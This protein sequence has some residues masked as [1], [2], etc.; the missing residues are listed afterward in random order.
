MIIAYNPGR[1]SLTVNVLN[2]FHRKICGNNR[3]FPV[4]LAVIQTEEELGYGE[5]IDCFCSQII[6]NERIAV[7]DGIKQCI[8]IK[9]VFKLI[10]IA[11]GVLFKGFD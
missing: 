8:L 2:R 10:R 11:E 1:D 7:H 5:I 6:N 4:F 9:C 3:G